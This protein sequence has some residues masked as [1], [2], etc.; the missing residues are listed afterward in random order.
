VRRSGGRCAGRGLRK[1]RWKWGSSHPSGTISEIVEEGKVSVTSNKVRRPAGRA[2]RG[3]AL[4]GAQ[5][6]TVSRNARGE[7]DPA[8]KISREGVRLPFPAVF[9]SAGGADSAPRGSRTTW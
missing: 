5:G 4:S 8:I 6:N 1:R 9:A 2:A 3:R 7:D